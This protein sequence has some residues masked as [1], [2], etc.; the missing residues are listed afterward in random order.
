MT[1]IRNIVVVYNDEERPLVSHLGILLY[2]LL[3]VRIS[4]FGPLG[5]L[6]IGLT[7]ITF[8]LSYGPFV[9]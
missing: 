3:Y 1:S 9:R 7:G 8:L 6:P 4:V 2:D 5:L